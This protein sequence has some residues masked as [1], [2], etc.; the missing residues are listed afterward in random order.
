M[1]A[2]QQQMMV[3]DPMVMQ[4]QL[5]PRGAQN[6][7]LGLFIQNNLFRGPHPPGWQAQV[8][9][10]E[11]Q[12][13]AM[14]LA[15]AIMLAMP[16]MVDWHKA[17]LMAIEFEKKV[18]TEKHSKQQYD[19][20]MLAKQQEMA[21]KRQANALGLE[22]QVQAQAQLQQQQQ[23]QQQM[24]I[25]NQ[26]ARGMG[27]PGQALQHLQRPMQTSQIP[28]QPQPFAMG[29]ANPGMIQPQPNQPQF[30]MQ[31][32]QAPPQMSAGPMMTAQDRS[33]VMALANRMLQQTPEHQR[34]AIRLNLNSR[35]T[36]AQ[37]AEAEAAGR[38]PLLLFFQ[39][40]ALN[41][42]QKNRANA[43][44]QGRPG[45]PPG[46]GQPH[47]PGQMVNPSGQPG[48]F[49]QG[50]GA[51]PGVPPTSGPGRDPGQGPM[52]GF[53]QQATPGNPQGPGQMARSQMPFN[54]PP[55]Q[56][57]PAALAR[58]Q[59][60]ARA[61]QQSNL[62]AQQQAG[63]LAGPPTASQSPSM[64]T[65]NAPMQQAPV[66][67]NQG[68]PQ[69]ATN[70]LNPTFN[71]N[72]NPRPQPMMN[73]QAAMQAMMAEK[74]SGVPDN[75]MKE[76]IAKWQ[77][78]Q[79]MSALQAQR[80]PQMPG[81]ADHLQA[82]AMNAT[83][84]FGAA[85]PQQFPQQTQ[86]AQ[87]PGAAMPPSSQ[88]GMMMTQAMQAQ[89]ANQARV[90]LNNHPHAK[91]MMQS[92]DIPPNI[93]AHLSGKVALPPGTKKWA[94]LHQWQNTT[95]QLSEEMVAQLDNMQKQ[96]F[97]SLLARNPVALNNM[98]QQPPAPRPIAGNSGK[99]PPLPPD[100]EVPKFGVTPEEIQRFRRQD[101]FKEV[102]DERIPILVLK[103]KHDAFVRNYWQNH[104][105][106]NGNAA[107]LGPNA[108]APN[109]GLVAPQPP[110][111]G[112][113]A[114]TTLKK[115][116]QNTSVPTARPVK[117]V[118]N[119]NPSSAQQAK[120]NLK[121]SSTDDLADAGQTGTFEQN[122]SLQKANNSGQAQ[123]PAQMEAAMP[124]RPQQGPPNPE[125]SRLQAL[126]REEGVRNSRNPQQNIA[127]APE[128]LEVARQK[129]T[130][131]SILVGQL[132][133]HIKPWFSMT[134]NEDRARLFFRYR[135]RL[136]QQFVDGQKL[137]GPQK[138]VLSI[139]IAELDEMMGLFQALK[140]EMT[141]L[142][143]K[144]GPRRPAQPAPQP[145]PEGPAPLN[146][147]NLEKQAQILKQAQNRGVNKSVQA[148][149]A[150]T[151]THAPFPLGAK[152]SPAG[153]PTYLNKASVTAENL[154]LPPRKKPKT[155]PQPTSSPATQQ[156][157]V[158]SPQVKAPSPE[159]K[160]QSPPEP[161]KPEPKTYRCPDQYCETNQTSPGF[162]TEEALQVH[163][164]QEHVKPNENPVQFMHDN[165]ALALGL[166]QQGNAKVTPNAAGQDSLAAPAMSLSTS[167]QGQTPMS[168]PDF[169][170]TP[171]SRDA[172][173]RRQGSSAGTPGRN[174]IKSENTPRLA[175]SK[176]PGARQ[177]SETPQMTLTDDPWG[178]TT[179]DPQNLFAT[180]APLE[181]LPGSLASDMAMYRSLTPNDTPE[182]SKDSGT[183]EP[184]SDISEGVNLD[185]DLTWQ[186]MDGGEVLM[187]MANFNM[188]GFEPMDGEMLGEDNFQISSF[189]DMNDFSKPFQFD[190]SFYS[191]DPS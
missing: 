60:Q 81:M 73:Q 43:M 37:L 56:L 16:A 185:I 2:P 117:N 167:K 33:Q 20:E 108:S 125:N 140:A 23:Q 14:S 173:M 137:V 147:A 13:K 145:A 35:F 102:P 65:L 5:N 169:A 136:L 186:T 107:V 165:L 91:S 133:Q 38:E 6:A 155:G 156:A 174:G 172:S 88:P 3:N 151:T 166:D 141:A 45:M 175:D 105:Q 82:N 177:E 163:I 152:K 52:M 191:M 77:A 8:T 26:M 11:R 39:Q 168:K 18:F 9:Q 132:I 51:Q 121:R 90:S 190:S 127:M 98:R 71:H 101:R 78:D 34:Q 113:T 131:A 58:A 63:V 61:Q 28:Q 42:I 87:Q 189:D 110:Q 84:Q 24:M 41:N 1:A 161:V 159:L 180:F 27:H 118:Q 114:A 30:S 15:T 153:G 66:P 178:N 138:D 150:P 48:H 148:P 32:G 103:L 106:G 76:L 10:A 95:R 122:Q 143:S 142:F 19:Q 25:M 116:Q 157:K 120:N 119:S 112:Q 46:V 49:P 72:N 187:H 70:T 124:N 139:S 83:N 62:M 21:R 75:K 68:N 181:T 100:V 12:G 59:A 126:V 31:M 176:L 17:G 57:D 129:V 183:S 64:N 97:I 182:S 92:M 184:N 162:L 4:A 160:R 158:P 171:M 93:L 44:M 111:Q 164:E 50:I 154:H 67:M 94:Q 134:Q 36:P 74:M 89:M 115:E 69:Q 128:E 144:Q 53:P 85:N 79:R 54:M 99:Y 55:G 29:M 86:Q 170:G 130:A 146:A 7:Q 22:H 123:Q 80:Q 188:E 149:H 96:Q 179:V 47:H 135:F 109:P 40:Q 104:A